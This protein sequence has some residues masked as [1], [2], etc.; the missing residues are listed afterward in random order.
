MVIYPV[1]TNDCVD[2]RVTPLFR[3]GPRAQRHDVLGDVSLLHGP[4]NGLL[5][6]IFHFNAYNMDAWWEIGVW[7]GMPG[8]YVFED[9][10]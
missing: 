3:T 1:T 2:G 7:Q 4:S 10:H 6:S 8:V 5:D 9:L